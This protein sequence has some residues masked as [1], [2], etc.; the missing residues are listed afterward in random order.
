MSTAIISGASALIGALSVVLITQRYTVALERERRSEARRDEY[1]RIISELLA[2]GFAKVE[3]YRPH[4]PI[5]AEYRGASREE[6]RALLELEA[7]ERFV[8]TNIDFQRAAAQAA[9]LAG[10]QEMLGP[11]AALRRHGVWSQGE[12]G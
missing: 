9:M 5:F 6:W 4:I 2:A 3:L 11:L 7:D 8:R 12:K 10:D 1:R